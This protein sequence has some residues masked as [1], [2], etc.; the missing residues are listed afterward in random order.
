[1]RIIG[2][3]ISL[4]GLI[5]LALTLDPVRKI[6]NITALDSIPKL[7]LTI[8]GLVLVIVGVIIASRFSYGRGRS[9]EVPIYRGNRIVGYR[10]SR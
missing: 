9:A 7:T 1:M 2:Y 4:I 8:V 10:R 5:A 6:V 3:L